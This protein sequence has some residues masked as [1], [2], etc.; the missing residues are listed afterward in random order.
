MVE[1]LLTV[2]GCTVVPTVEL[3]VV[4]EV[5]MVSVEAVT[6]CVLSGV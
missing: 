6:L 5:V 1:V 4:S 2:V 3:T